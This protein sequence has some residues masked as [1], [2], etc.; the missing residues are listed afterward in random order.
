[1]K[2]LLYD[3]QNLLLY[4]TMITIIMKTTTSYDTPSFDV[5][6]LN[7]YD[8][9]YDLI[10]DTAF[11]ATSVYN[12]SNNNS[13]YLN[14]DIALYFDTVQYLV[15]MEILLYG[16]QNELLYD[17]CITNIL[18]SQGLMVLSYNTT[19]STTVQVIAAVTY[20]CMI[21]NMCCRTL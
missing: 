17:T 3:Q 12:Q 19:S 21:K 1:M 9:I 8:T 11:D 20:F 5:V 15:R 18:R 10:F 7:T 4:A 14:Y 13:S 2:I 16:R 6:M